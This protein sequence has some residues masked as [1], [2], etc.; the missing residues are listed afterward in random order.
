MAYIGNETSNLDVT[1]RSY[2][3]RLALL[4]LENTLVF[5]QFAE[6]KPLPKNGGKAIYWNRFTNFSEITG[7]LTEG[8]APTVVQ[9]SATAV[10]ATLIQKGHVVENSD[11]LEMTSINDDAKAVVE[12]QSYIMQYSIDSSFRR[13]IYNTA[14][15]SAVCT[16]PNVFFQ[17][18]D[19]VTYAAASALPS[20]SARMTTAIIRNA[21]TKLKTNAVAPLD[22]GDYVLIVAPATAARLRADSVWQNANQYSGVYAEKIFNGECGKIEGARVVETQNIPFFAS[23]TA[24]NV[25]VSTADTSVYYSVLLGKGCLGSTDLGG[26]IERF[27]IHGADKSDPLNQKHSYGMKVT[28]VPKVLNYSCGVV[29]ATTD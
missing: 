17:V 6:S 12:R 2:Y 26:G 23:S 8:V 9:M 19:G 27:E 21:V 3:D 11:L 18:Y 1:V 15:N 22:G 5:K 7:T 14:A 29:I 20:T 13:E 10:S 28:Y 24:G 25:A 16:A 4:T